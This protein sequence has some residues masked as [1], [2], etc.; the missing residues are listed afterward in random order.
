MKKLLCL[1]LGAAVQVLGRGHRIAGAA[2]GPWIDLSFLIF[3][4]PSCC[5][6]LGQCEQ[7]AEV[8][9]RIQ[10]LDLETQAALAEAIQEVR[11]ITL[12]L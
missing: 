7:K 2:P 5:P 9:R 1:M 4:S 11:G 6:T 10:G 3:L 8:I 12:D